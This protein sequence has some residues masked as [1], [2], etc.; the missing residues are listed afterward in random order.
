MQ[1]LCNWKLTKEC[2]FSK[3]TSQNYGR[4]AKKLLGSMWPL[5]ISKHVLVTAGQ[6]VSHDCHLT[7]MWLC[8]SV[9]SYVQ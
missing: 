6:L 9:P 1:N 5:G 2:T 7:S 8:A 4:K 3:K